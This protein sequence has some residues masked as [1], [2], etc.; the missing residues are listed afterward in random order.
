MVRLLCVG[1]LFM[2]VN[3][4]AKAQ[5]TLTIEVDSLRSSKGS[6]IMDFRDGN[7]KELK[8][9][10]G[11]I[12]KDRSV[13][14]I[15]SLQPGKYSFRYFHDENSNVKMDTYWIGAP[16]EGIGFSNNAKIK[17]KAPDFEDTLFEIKGDTTIVC[18]PY[19]IKF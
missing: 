10:V 16:K 6:I 7:D 13:M 4:S 3:L 19:Y 17:F 1:V 5:V 18:T 12:S 2:L 14:V 15:D 8:A 9:I 11:R